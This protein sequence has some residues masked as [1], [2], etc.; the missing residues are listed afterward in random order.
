MS[1]SYR[2]IVADYHRRYPHQVRL[3]NSGDWRHVHTGRAHYQVTGGPL[4]WWSEDGFSVFGFTTADQAAAFRRWS[5]TCG[6]DWTVEPRAQPLPH[7]EPPPERP[8]TSGPT[9]PGRAPPPYSG[10]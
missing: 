3:A 2:K 10:S 8:A 6:I 4:V 7:P 1:R 9:P 5:E